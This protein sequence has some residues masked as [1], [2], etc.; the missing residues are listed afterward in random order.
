MNTQ[1]PAPV[2]SQLPLPAVPQPLAQPPNAAPVSVG[3]VMR[4]VWNYQQ[5]WPPVQPQ[6][7]STSYFNHPP[8]MQLSG[9]PL[10]L[11]MLQQGSSIQQPG[12]SET[13]PHHTLLASGPVPGASN[14]VVSFNAQNQQTN[15]PTQDYFQEVFKSDPNM[16]PMFQANPQQLN[17]FRA[18]HYFQSIFSG[19][20][21]LNASNDSAFI[22]LSD[23]GACLNFGRNAFFTENGIQACGQ[24]SGKIK[25]LSQVV[26][27]FTP[28][29]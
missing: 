9:N 3:Q 28:F 8:Q 13:I 22:G 21:N 25:T 1:Q 24:W 7:M 26:D 14:Q 15:L 12:S 2:N 29:Y 4:P 18:R 6:Q 20:I 19:V 23:D 10:Q 17:L 5:S 27:I 16:L 11:Q